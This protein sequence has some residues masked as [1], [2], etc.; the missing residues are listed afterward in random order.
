MNFLYPQG[1]KQALTF[2]FDDNQDFDKKLVEI[3][4]KN[5]LKGTFNINSGTLCGN[6]GENPDGNVYVKPEE[7][8]EL[9]KGHEVA[10]HGVD[11]KFIAGLSDV[12]IV[13]EFLNDRRTLEQITGN[14]VQGAAYAFGWHDEHI[15][16]ILK[17]LGF[18]Y[19]RGVDSTFG[20][21]PPQDFLDWKP[22]CHQGC[23]ELFELGESFLNCPGYIEL[24]LMYVW[25]HSYEFG[26][27]GDW[28]N[29][30]KFCEM[31]S[32]KDFIWYATNMEIC[33]YINATRSLEFSADGKK[34]YNPTLIEVFYKN[35]SSVC[36][37]KPG[38][39]KIL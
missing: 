5:N 36:S 27:S 17:K 25:G 7:V 8:N 18:K 35:D 15:M 31:M 20:F 21:F 12:M 2:S 28:S 14:L 3:F 39:Y 16:D 33:D 30:E 19:S 22:T 38:E 34:A 11:H 23:E 24:P 6:I 29:I 10:A 9:Y 32:N 13:N 4:N 1:K 37:I 26:R